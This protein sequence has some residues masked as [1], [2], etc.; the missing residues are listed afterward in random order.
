MGESFESNYLQTL[1]CDFSVRILDVGSNRIEFSIWDLAGQIGFSS[2]HP[3]YFFGAS[4][5]IIVYDVTDPE[6][7]HSVTDWLDR[8]LDLCGYETP[9]VMI[10]GNKIDLEGQVRISGAMHDDLLERIRSGYSD[11]ISYLA[12]YRTSAKTGEN[13]ESLF[14]SLGAKIVSSPALSLRLDTDVPIDDVIPG[15][16]HVMFHEIWGP[17]ILATSP[18]SIRLGDPTKV[19]GNVARLFSSFDFES[20]VDQRIQSGKIPWTEPLG[21]GIFFAFVV[22]NT[23]ARGGYELHVIVILVST[24][25][26]PIASKNEDIL[27]A[28]SHSAM[29]KIVTQL[30]KS[31]R[32]LPQGDIPT[33]QIGDHIVPILTELRSKCYSALFDL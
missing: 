2:V 7:Y 29:N 26:I 19:M 1:G 14:G 9:M 16:L 31:D 28:L 5:A 25:Y 8:F 10:A 3:T 20:I 33:N 21:F 13:I 30:L 4:A 17:H 12:G 18:E 27:T 24:D 22:K 6:S 23:L 15:V 32:H 11:R